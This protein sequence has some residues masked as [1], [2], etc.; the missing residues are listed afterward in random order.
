MSDEDIVD[1]TYWE[2]TFNCKFKYTDTGWELISEGFH[3][4]ININFN[5]KR[6]NKTH[7]KPTK[8][9]SWPMKC[10][11]CGKFMYRKK[12][13]ANNKWFIGCSK[14]GAIEWE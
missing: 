6:S 12:S 1:I 7:R 11:K 13:L 2:K 14:C 4:Q 10:R 3:P 9:H 5:A 8:S